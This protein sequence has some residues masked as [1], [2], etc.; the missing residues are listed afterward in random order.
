MNQFNSYIDRELYIV[1]K[2]KKEYKFL[3][4]STLLTNE[5]TKEIGLYLTS[6][7]AKIKVTE[8]D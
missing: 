5:K 8:K 1:L 4:D 6:K 3:I 7:N 2:N